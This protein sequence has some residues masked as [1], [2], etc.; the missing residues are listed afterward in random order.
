MVVVYWHLLL[1]ALDWI[2]KVEVLKLIW[3]VNEGKDTAVIVL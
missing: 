3:L 2:Y 1:F